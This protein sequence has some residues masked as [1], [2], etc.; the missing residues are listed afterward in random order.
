MFR[1]CIER[2]FPKKYSSRMWLL[3]KFGRQNYK[4]KRLNSLSLWQIINGE[5]NEKAEMLMMLVCACLLSQPMQA[6]KKEVTPDDARLYSKS[7]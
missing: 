5:Y 4:K 3:V 2:L 6:Q 7:R 1:H